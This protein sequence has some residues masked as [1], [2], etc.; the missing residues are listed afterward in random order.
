MEKWKWLFE[1][2]CECKRSIS[3]CDGIFELVPRW[4]KCSNVLGDYA[5]K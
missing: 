3:T 5:E 1:N 2:G 4:V